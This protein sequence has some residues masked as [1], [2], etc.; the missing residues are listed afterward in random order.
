MSSSPFRHLP[1]S[2]TVVRLVLVLPI[3]LLIVEGRFLPALLLFMM[4]S[5]K[6]ICCAIDCSCS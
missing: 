2:I 6:K 4:Q 3:A 1:N 5:F